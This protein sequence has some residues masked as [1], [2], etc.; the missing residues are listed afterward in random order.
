MNVQLTEPDQSETY[1]PPELI[2]R[3]GIYPD[4]AVDNLATV[5]S[6]YVESKRQDGWVEGGARKD[7]RGNAHER[8]CKFFTPGLLKIMSKKKAELSVRISHSGQYSKEI[9]RAV[10]VGYAK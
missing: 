5:K 3:H 8:S 9:S 1:T 7:E 2:T 4:F 6:L 10:H